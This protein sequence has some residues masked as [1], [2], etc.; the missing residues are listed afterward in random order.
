MYE[1]TFGG[2]LAG[3]SDALL[4]AT[5]SAAAV[6]TMTVAPQ[7][8]ANVA[9][10]VGTIYIN[11]SN[12]NNIFLGTG[13]PNNLPDAYYGT[14]IYQSMDAGATWSLVTGQ[15]VQTVSVL[16]PPRPPSSR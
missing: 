4:T 15:E 5:P 14:G 3:V 7:S 16:G 11:P 8:P 6:G 13:E 12:P 9:I 1:V 2:S 10:Y